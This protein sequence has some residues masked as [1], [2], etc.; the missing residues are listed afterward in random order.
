[1]AEAVERWE[2]LTYKPLPWETH[3]I[4]TAELQPHGWG[5]FKGA[6][7]PLDFAGVAA[8]IDQTWL[9]GDNRTTIAPPYALVTLFEDPSLHLVNNRLEALVGSQ[10]STTPVARTFSSTISNNIGTDEADAS[11]KLSTASATIGSLAA[12]IASAIKGASS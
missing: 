8:G 1:M 4:D 11:T 2:R 10:P 7:M 6:W 12:R 5:P 3:P 9:K